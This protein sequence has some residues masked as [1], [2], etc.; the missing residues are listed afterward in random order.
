[1]NPTRNDLP[2]SARTALADLLNGELAD[3]IHLTLQA[4]Q[5]HWNVKGPQFQQ[6]HELF[7]EV[8]EAS[9]GWVDALAERAVQLGGVADGTLTGVAHRTRLAPYETRVFSG[10]EHVDELSSRLA[11][12]GK[13]IR[14]AIDRATELG[15]AGTGDLCTEISR[16]VDKHLWFLEA[17]L[18]TD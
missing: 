9:T 7:D 16:A 3:A 17:H 4:K 18:Q 12:F 8:Y 14:A 2:E 13:T 1:M 15:D 6:L 11:A 10:R 5:A